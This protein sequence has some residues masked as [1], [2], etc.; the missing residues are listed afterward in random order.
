MVAPPFFVESSLM[1]TLWLGA[2]AAIALLQAD[3]AAAQD[4]SKAPRMG[5]WGFDLSG[6]DAA[7]TP[8]QNFY[9]YANGTYLKKLEIPADRSRFGAFDSL[10][11]L[12]QARMHAVLDKA[13]A[14]KAATGEAAQVGAL[15]RSFLDE[16][17]VE[18][19]GAKPLAGDLAVI[20]AQKS[21]SDIAHTMG[22]S[23]KTFGGTFFSGQ[24]AGDAK[25]PDHLAQP[26]CERQGD[27][28]HGD[29]D[30]QGLLEPRGP[31]RR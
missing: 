4:L 17:K 19:L 3:P 20:R 24:V 12:S 15:Y 26:G 23:L 30:R 28:R 22:V 10:N 16:A 6:R 21:R 11:E 29:R 9:D 31:A 2:A 14:D 13:A 18:A 1:K 7:V 27:R 8:A 25:D 5:T